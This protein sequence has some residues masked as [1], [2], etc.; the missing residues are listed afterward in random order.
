MANFAST[1][2]VPVALYTGCVIT[3]GTLGW[4][5]LDLGRSPGWWATLA[6]PYCPGSMVEHPKS[7]ST[8]LRSETWWRA[9]YIPP[10]LIQNCFIL[11]MVIVCTLLHKLCGACHPRE[12]CYKGET[13]FRPPL[14]AELNKGWQY[15]NNLITTTYATK[16][17][18]HSEQIANAR[19]KLVPSFRCYKDHGDGDV[20][21]GLE[22][23]A[24]AVQALPGVALLHSR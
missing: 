17:S 23:R 18:S 24:E 3:S 15:N 20:G 1:Q 7:K 8:Q 6:A 16:E 21:V 12:S 11:L 10:S 4:V 13:S 14:F 5:D 2:T 19:H 9:L 22:G